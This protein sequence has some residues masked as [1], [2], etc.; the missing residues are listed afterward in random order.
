LTPQDRSLAVSNDTTIDSAD[1]VRDLG[2][3]LDTELSM[4]QHIAKQGRSQGVLEG[5]EHPLIHLAEPVLKR[6]HPL[7]PLLLIG[8]AKPQSPLMGNE[9]C[10]MACTEK[11]SSL[12]TSVLWNRPILN[13]ISLLPT[14]KLCM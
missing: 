8:G 9:H 4:E 12:L 6:E 5:A 7:A 3:F 2:V 14:H 11:T 1:V 13:F 10:I